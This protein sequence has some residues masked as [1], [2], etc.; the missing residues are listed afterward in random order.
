MTRGI[1]SRQRGVGHRHERW[2][3]LRWTRTP[4]LTRVVWSV[5]RSRV[6][7][8]PRCWRQVMRKCSH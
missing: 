8:T 4:W 2:D 7:L 1:L 3:R 6:V 5:R